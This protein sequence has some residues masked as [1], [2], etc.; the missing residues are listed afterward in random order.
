LQVAG[1]APFRDRISL[2]GS[3]DGNRQPVCHVVIFEAVQ[4]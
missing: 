2:G 3:I 4:R 1:A